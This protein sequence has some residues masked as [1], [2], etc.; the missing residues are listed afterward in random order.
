[1]NRSRQ[2]LRMRLWDDNLIPDVN[3]KMT[4]L[5]ELAGLAK[6]TLCRWKLTDQ[7]RHSTKKINKED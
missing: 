1:M 4:S 6:I 3:I 2:E 5:R 7:A